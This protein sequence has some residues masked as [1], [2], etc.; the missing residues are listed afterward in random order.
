MERLITENKTYKYFEYN[1]EAEFEKVI[2]DHS[3]HIFGKNTVYID[4]KS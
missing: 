1:N 3:H 4:I 2:V